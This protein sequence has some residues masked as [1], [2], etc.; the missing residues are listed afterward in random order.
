MFHSRAQ[1]EPEDSEESEDSEDFLD[2]SEIPPIG[3][4]TCSVVQPIAQPTI[5]VVLATIQGSPVR[6][7][8]DTF[9]EVTAL[10]LSAWHKLSPRPEIQP[11][12]IKLHGVGGSSVSQG[13]VVLPVMLQVGFRLVM[14]PPYIIN[15]DAMPTGVDLLLGI[16][17]QNIPTTH[18]A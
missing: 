14:V 5:A 17:T 2:L 8:V 12:Q 10:S 16:D 6:T 9:A 11:S 7:G 15:D 3:D 1:M 13:F 18:L 4:F